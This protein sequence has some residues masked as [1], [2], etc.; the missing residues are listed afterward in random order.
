MLNLKHCARPRQLAEDMAKDVLPG[1]SAR[2]RQP[3]SGCDTCHRASNF[4]MEER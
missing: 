2:G 4:F 3:K 1:V